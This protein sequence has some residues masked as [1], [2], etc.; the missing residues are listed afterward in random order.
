MSVPPLLA[1]LRAAKDAAR[2][3]HVHKHIFTAGSLSMQE[4]TTLAADAERENIRRFSAAS[5]T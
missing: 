1:S 2:S 5:T 4:E 3:I